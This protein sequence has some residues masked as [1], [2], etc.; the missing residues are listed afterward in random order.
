MKIDLRGV[1]KVYYLLK[2][3]TRFYVN[4]GGVSFKAGRR[5]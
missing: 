1:S 3:P 4:T 2:I 5:P